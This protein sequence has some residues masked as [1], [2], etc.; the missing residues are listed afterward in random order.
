MTAIEVGQSASFTKTITQDDISHFAD[1]T[2]D[3]NPVHLDEEYASGTR[4]G[5]RIAHGMLTAALIS[6]VLGT[7]LPGPGAI[8]LGQTVRFL[9]P[10]FPGDEITATVT[11]ERYNTERGRMLL[12]TV[13]RNAM[14]EY[15]LTG[16]AE[17]YYRPE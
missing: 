17:V 1:L 15:V 12:S 10:V 11:V 14:G 4:F 8:Y 3:R 5:R 7:K 13:C 2:G 9:K 6:T 16:E